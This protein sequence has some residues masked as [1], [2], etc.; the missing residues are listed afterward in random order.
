MLIKKFLRLIVIGLAIYAP[1][2]SFNAVA[3]VG[4]PTLGLTLTC[5]RPTSTCKSG[6]TLSDDGKTCVADAPVCV[7]VDQADCEAKNPGYE[8]AIVSSSDN[9]GGHSAGN[10]N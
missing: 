9:G 8:C 4:A 7:Y 1:L 10:G 3:V 2:Q 5:Y 6:Y